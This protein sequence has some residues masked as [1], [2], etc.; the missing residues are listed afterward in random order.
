MQAKKYIHA[1]TNFC[2]G[3]TSVSSGRSHR[4]IDRTI[5]LQEPTGPWYYLAGEHADTNRDAAE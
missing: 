1:S 5:G 2:G 3:E 4:P